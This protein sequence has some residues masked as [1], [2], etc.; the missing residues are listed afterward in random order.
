VQE[1]KMKFTKTTKSYVNYVRGY[2]I[3]QNCCYNIMCLIALSGSYYI[4]WI[5]SYPIWFTIHSHK[6]EGVL[7][8]VRW[9]HQGT[10]SSSYYTYWL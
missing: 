10:V 6:S 4:S 9:Q 8:Y 1:I 3:W 2:I 7:V 5:I